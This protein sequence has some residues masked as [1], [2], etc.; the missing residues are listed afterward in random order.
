MP[1]QNGI[2]GGELTRVNKKRVKRKAGPIDLRRMIS[3]FQIPPVPYLRG[4]KLSTKKK[5][6]ILPLIK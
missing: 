1:R 4:P 2:Q 6:T 5:T 3:P